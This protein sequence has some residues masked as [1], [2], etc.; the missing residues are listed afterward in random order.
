MS[1]QRAMIFNAISH[2]SSVALTASASVLPFESS[3]LM[4]P[5][6]LLSDSWTRTTARQFTFFMSLRKELPS[7]LHEKFFRMSAISSFLAA[8]RALRQVD[9]DRDRLSI[10]P[11]PWLVMRATTAVRWLL[12]MPRRSEAGPNSERMLRGSCRLVP[13]ARGVR[14]ARLGMNSGSS[15][16]LGDG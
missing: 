16:V 10:S 1:E 11:P 5:R 15:A 13:S 7:K 3:I 8:A 12:E 6:M 9:L 4:M 2:L 14:Q